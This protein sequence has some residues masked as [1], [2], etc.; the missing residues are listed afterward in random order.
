MAQ[1]VVAY[2][3]GRPFARIDDE[4]T[5]RNREWVAARR[6]AGDSPLRWIDPAVGLV[7]TDFDALAAWAEGRGSDG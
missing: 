7:R 1:Y 3:A 6:A 4:I 2:A 5:D